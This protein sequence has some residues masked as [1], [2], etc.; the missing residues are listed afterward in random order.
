MLA[1]FLSLE[2]IDEADYGL[3]IPDPENHDRKHN[4]KQNKKLNE[5]K[6][7]NTCSDGETV[8]DESI[9]SKVKKKKKKKSKDAKEN[10]KV[11]H[12]NTGIF[13]LK[14][15]LKCRLIKCLFNSL[16]LTIL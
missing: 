6:Q 5:Q 15:I 2:E 7:N 11:Q 14:A 13:S 10:Q 3:N 9:K 8:N 12:S 1:G 16:F 4:S